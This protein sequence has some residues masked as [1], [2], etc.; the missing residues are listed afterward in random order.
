MM[1]ALFDS[2]KGSRMGASMGVARAEDEV[3]G[4]E[5]HEAKSWKDVKSSSRGASYGVD[6]TEEKVEEEDGDEKM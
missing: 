5:E 2:P 1:F 3:E 4:D 6:W